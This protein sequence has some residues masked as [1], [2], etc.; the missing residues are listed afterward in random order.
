MCAEKHSKNDNI[1]LTYNY[2]TDNFCSGLVTKIFRVERRLYSIPF[3]TCIISHSAVVCETTRNR[4]YLIEFTENCPILIHEVTD[5][6]SFKPTTKWNYSGYTFT[7]D[8]EG[9]SVPVISYSV[10]YVSK[11]F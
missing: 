10:Q 8:A 7:R 9:V 3:E 4:A 11:L 6:W 2:K 5:T 1:K